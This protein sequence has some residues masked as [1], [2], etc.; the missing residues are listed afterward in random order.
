MFI[1]KTIVELF[2]ECQIENVISCI[3]FK[4]EKVIFVGYKETMSKNRKEA[5]ERFFSLRGLNIK[6][7]YD[8]VSRYNYNSIVNK[9]NYI[10]QNNND[11]CFDLTG[12]KELVLAAMGDV[13]A[14]YNVPMV[15]FNI[16]NGDL[17]K[18]NNCDNLPAPQMSFLTIEES[19]VLNGG[20]VVKN[21]TNN[22]NWKLNK[23]FRNDIE[24]V[25][26]I[27]KN[28]CYTWNKQSTVFGM[29]E[30]SGV[31]SKTL[32]VNVNLN[33]INNQHFDILDGTSIFNQLSSKGIITYSVN[34]N[35]ILKYSYKNAQIRRCLLKA[36]NILELYAYMI[37]HEINEEHPCFYDDIDTGVYVDWDGIISKYTINNHEI[38]NEVDIILMRGSVPI[39]ISCKNGD[40]HKDALYEL[41]S[42][43]KKYGGEYTKKILLATHISSNTASKKHILQRAKDMNISVID[44]IEQMSKVEFKKIF[45][46]KVR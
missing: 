20:A 28:D 39:F 5:L 17:I 10:I 25:W 8:V 37:A 14:R 18:V 29:L 35:N 32:D 22:E 40:V 9:L 41:E 36:G 12:G 31:I 46:N 30:K 43:A 45:F 33:D 42:V 38:R 7:V 4:P 6:I 26:D 13:G 3:K 2:D 23:S 1:I 15:Q 24:I 11:C 16:K 34:K 27:C 21:H 19:I 44:N